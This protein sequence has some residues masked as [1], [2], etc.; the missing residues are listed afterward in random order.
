MET[1]N[2]IISITVGIFGIMGAIY[3]F[4]K[5][6]SKK[7]F[8]PAISSLFIKEGNIHLVY[9]D[10][11]T[12]QVTFN[13]SDSRAVLGRSF[14]IFFRSEEVNKLRPYLRHKL[15]S[16]NTSKLKEIII[17]DQKPYSDGLDGS[18]EILYPGAPSLSSDQSKVV[19]TIEKYATAS[20]LVQVDLING[21]WKE[22]FSVEHF[23]IINTGLYKNKLLVGS[24]QIR[25]NKGRDICYK[26][27]DHDGKS[28]LEFLDY[29]G[30]ME[31]R[32]EAVMIR[33]A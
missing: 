5:W 24:S 7:L 16:L 15:M 23:D 18:F 20:Q 26:V 4:N 19:F 22:L 14:I 25:S 9:A 29:Q 12:K 10:G 1:I 27:C 31:F 28:L 21:K 32:S 2:L 3:A 6:V 17:S 8:K 33:E 13:N 11:N 30:Y